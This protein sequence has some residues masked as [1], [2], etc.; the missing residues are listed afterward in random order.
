[1]Q[2]NGINLGNWKIYQIIVLIEWLESFRRPNT[3]EYLP[4]TSSL[5]I[6][7]R[8]FIELSIKH[9]KYCIFLVNRTIV[10]VPI[11]AA[12]GCGPVVRPRSWT[13]D[14]APQPPDRWHTIYFQ[15]IY[16]SLHLHAS[17]QRALSILYLLQSLLRICRDLSPLLCISEAQFAK[18]L[19]Q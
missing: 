1:M 16:N 18:N 8:V 2:F 9:Q 15:S 4:T 10:G 3:S 13:D 7:L 19:R 14:H 17:L 6:P 5:L 12:G 11:V